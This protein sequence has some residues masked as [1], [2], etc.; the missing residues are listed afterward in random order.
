MPGVCRLADTQSLGPPK[1]E[2]KKLVFLRREPSGAENLSRG[3]RGEQGREGTGAGSRAGPGGDQG[4][5]AQTVSHLPVAGASLGGVQVL[6]EPPLG[7]SVPC[8]QTPGLDTP[9]SYR[10]LRSD[11]DLHWLGLL[12]GEAT[13]QG[14][15]RT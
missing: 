3:L 6:I 15:K 7:L 14:S 13:P 4:Q 5:A 11:H 2:G 10:G 1:Q 12:L 8:S 9:G